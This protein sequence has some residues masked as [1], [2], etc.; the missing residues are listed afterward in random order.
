MMNSFV[1]VRGE[2]E[3]EKELWVGEVLLLNRS[4]VGEGTGR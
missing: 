3:E 1:L 2:S 4:V